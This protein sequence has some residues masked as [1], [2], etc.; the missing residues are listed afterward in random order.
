MNSDKIDRWKADI[1][2]SIDFYNEWF[3]QFAPKTFR[4]AR[5]EAI[6]R[7]HNAIQITR[8]CKDC[9]AQI[10]L[11]HPGVLSVLRMCTAPPLA[12]DRLAGLSGVRRHLLTK[13]ENEKGK[14]SWDEAKGR[15]LQK[16]LDSISRVL[17]KMLDRDLFVWL[18][19]GR[20][21]TRDELYRAETVVADRLTGAFSD[22]IIRNAQE[23]RQL[24]AIAS[25]LKTLGYRELTESERS[26]WRSLPKGTYG[27]RLNVPITS[28]NNRKVN[29]PVDA[30]VRPTS[31]GNPLL[32][33]AKSA[34]DFTNTNKRRKEEA[35]KFSQLCDTYGDVNYILF[36]C[37]YFG[38]PYLGYE[39]AEGIDWVWEHRIED[40]REFGL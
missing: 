3:L 40:L 33:E 24:Q 39:A 12:R 23:Q 7:V 18:D 37:G 2:E 1:Q 17:R 32:I 25:F 38:S 9:S 14:L 6:K 10:I 19:T 15:R 11:Q 30:V 8:G 34:G 13:I 35:Q 4:E 5:D 20:S 21:A 22:P 28:Q 31:G 36:L 16:E 27:F 26:D 29:I